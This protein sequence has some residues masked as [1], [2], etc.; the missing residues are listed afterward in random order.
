METNPTPLGW[1][2]HSVEMTT[3]LSATS[4]QG[5]TICFTEPEQNTLK[6]VHEEF[7]KSQSNTDKEK[8]KW[9]RTQAPLTP[10][11]ATKLQPSKQHST[12]TK[13]ETD[14]NGA[15]QK[16]RNK[17]E[18]L[19]PTHLEQRRPEHLVGKDSFFTSGAGK[20]EELPAIGTFIL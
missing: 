17:H 14:T 15:G 10:V 4:A 1:K 11:Y 16:A 13:T 18:Q 12:R 9:R 7:P 2:S 8:R 6:F 20:A 5:P 19:R 3:R